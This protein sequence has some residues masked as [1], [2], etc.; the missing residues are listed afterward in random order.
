MAIV[1]LRTDNAGKRLGHCRASVMR[2]LDTISQ[3]LA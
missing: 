1:D 3:L 2:L